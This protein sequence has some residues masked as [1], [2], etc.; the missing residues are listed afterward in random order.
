AQQRK[1]ELAAGDV[2]GGQRRLYAIRGQVSSP[3]A[4]PPGCAFE[5]RCDHAVAACREAMPDLRSAGP[6]RA[7]RCILVSETAAV[8][9]EIA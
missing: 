5:P 4:P 9:L 2:V 1:R 6:R 8:P 7:A 3:L